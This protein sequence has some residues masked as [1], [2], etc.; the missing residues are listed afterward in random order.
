MG[1]GPMPLRLQDLV[2]YFVIFY[3]FLVG[4]R[5]KNDFPVSFLIVVIVS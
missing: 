5:L 1:V 3:A 4:R 2:A